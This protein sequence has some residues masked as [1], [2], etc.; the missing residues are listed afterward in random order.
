MWCTIYRLY[1]DGQR[2]PSEIAQ[3][4][5]VYGWLYMYSKV[6]V[7]GMPKCQA[8]LLR[9]P[10]SPA[11]IKDLI[12]PLTCCNLMAIDKGVMRLN[13]SDTFTQ[14]Y[15]KQAWLCVPSLAPAREHDAQS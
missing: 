12:E 11:G 1:K 3:A 4:N 15:V 9:E 14:R 6:P 8:H 2:L 7:T 5:G 13:G 10:G